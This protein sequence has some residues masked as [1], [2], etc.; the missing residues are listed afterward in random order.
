MSDPTRPP[1]LRVQ[2]LTMRFGSSTALDRVDLSIPRG[3]ITS[4]LGPSGCGKTTFL[5]LVAGFL[6]PTAG[7]ITLAGR[8]VAGEGTWVAPQKRRVGYLPQEGALFPHLD[9]AGNIGFGLPRAERTPGRIAELLDLVE[10]P[11]AMATR[12]PHEL[13]GGQQQRVALARA[14]APAPELVLLDEPFSALDAS[15]RGSTGRSVTRALRAADAT[16]V[17]VTH[18]QR[19]ALSLSDQVVTLRA[20]RLVQSADP[21]TTY[22]FPAD[23]EQATFVGRA[24][25]LPGVVSADSTTVECA[26]GCLAVRAGNAP[27]PGACRVALRPEEVRLAESG[28]AA[29]V[30]DVEFQGHDASVRLLVDGTTLVART[31]ADAMP[32]VGQVVRCRVDRSVLVFPPTDR[33]DTQER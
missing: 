28:I 18:D 17:L 20:G 26:L 6:T 10:L 3:A 14:L 31:S 5:R 1:A 4:V 8:K 27:A 16:G 29:T 9:V 19:E 33:A 30:Q 21:A 2:G 13:S 24:T 12:A 22:L 23:A 15:L 32:R 11:T 7:S 25:L